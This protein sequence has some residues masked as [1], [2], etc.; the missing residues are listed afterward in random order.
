VKELSVGTSPNL[1]DRLF[2]SINF[3]SSVLFTGR[4]AVAY[5]GVQID[6]DRT[7]H[8]FTGSSLGEKGI[9][10]T[11]VATLGDD[12]LRVD[13]SVLLQAVLQQVPARVN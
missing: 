7:R 2:I 3:G 6:K 4:Q 13:T 10:G 8:V 9:V 1:V 11:T 12:T 5:R